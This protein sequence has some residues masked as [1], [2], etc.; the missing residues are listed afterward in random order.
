[1]KKIREKLIGQVVWIVSAVPEVCD[2]VVELLGCS[3]EGDPL[4]TVS[5]SSVVEPRV[6]FFHDA[7]NEGINIMMI[8]FFEK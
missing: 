1:M 2:S 3:V 5:V 8:Y 7:K 4:G 6:L